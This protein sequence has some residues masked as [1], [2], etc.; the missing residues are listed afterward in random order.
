MRC[1]ELHQLSARGRGTKGEMFA[2][3]LAQLEQLA[4]A[5]DHALRRRRPLRPKRVP[6]GYPCLRV[7][8]MG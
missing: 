8:G 3:A 1:C 7:G 2:A 5:D 6:A 4:A